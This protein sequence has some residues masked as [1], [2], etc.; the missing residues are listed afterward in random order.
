MIAAFRGKT[1]QGKKDR[2]DSAQ[3]IRRGIKV[4]DNHLSQGLPKVKL[5]DFNLLLVLG[6]GSFGK[7]CSM[8]VLE[9]LIVKKS[10]MKM[11]Q[12][13]ELYFIS[14]LTVLFAQ[15]FLAEHKS[16]KEVYAI[17]SMKKDV[18]IEEDDVEG[19]LNE[20]QVLSLQKK[21]PFLT[22][23]HSSFQT[24]EHLFLVMEYVNGGDLMFH[25]LELRRFSEEMT[26]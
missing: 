22:G 5:D 6:K 21:P 18:I 13:N 9:K 23:L 11:A 7:V 20:R 1:V 15:V 24:K 3:E 10:C 12:G 2:D 8:Y 25:M 19:V 14:I 16:T 17:K 26:R 4:E